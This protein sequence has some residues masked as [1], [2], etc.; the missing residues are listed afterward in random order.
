[1]AIPDSHTRKLP[2]WLRWG[3]KIVL[4][5]GGIYVAIVLILL[6][7][8]YRLAFTGWSFPEPWISPPEGAVIDDVRFP[9]SDGNTIAGWWM[10][11]PDWTPE[12]GAVIYFHG[13][14]ENVTTCGKAVRNWRNELH[15]GALGIDYPGYGRSTGTPD[16]QNCY[17]AAQAALD[18]LARD[19]KVPAE[20]V[21][22]VGQSMGGAMATDLAFRQ[23]CRLLVTAGAF[24][25][26]PD[27][28]QYRYGWLPARYLVRLRFDNLAKMRT[29][30]TPVFITHGTADTA[31]PFSEG[32]RLY[33]AVS[34]A[35]KQFFPTPGHGH[36]QP[37][38][39]E[40]YTAVR[41][42]LNETARANTTA[43]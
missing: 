10:P 11:P 30:E 31:V 40:F 39:A 38:T 14:G 2:P 3:R 27:V 29:L 1:M 6:A 23:R 8:Q 36:S 43:K 24:T 5:L 42:F 34:K 28:A 7:G 12:M 19:K 33:A 16:E 20:N 25:S 15:R 37:D 35:P 21:V 26:F 32:E 9:A 18:W 17:A 4:W 13:N 41:E 22:V